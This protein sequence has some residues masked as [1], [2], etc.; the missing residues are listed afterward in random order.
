MS[1]TKRFL[2]TFGLVIGMIAIVFTLL[3]YRQLALAYYQFQ[4]KRGSVSSADVCCFL[5]KH[6]FRK[7]DVES[8]MGMGEASATPNAFLYGSLKVIY[9]GGN[10][11][12]AYDLL[13][14]GKPDN[15]RL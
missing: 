1:K 11:I 9:D 10:Y 5:Q 14:D 7:G 15:P 12:A 6:S 4:W 2:V 3:N 8:V 13:A